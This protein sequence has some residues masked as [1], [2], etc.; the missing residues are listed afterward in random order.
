MRLPRPILPALLVGYEFIKEQ[1][2]TDHQHALHMSVKR[3]PAA[4]TVAA[5]TSKVVEVDERW[6][7]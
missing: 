5:E 2:A 7:G 3:R 6:W 4:V 1:G